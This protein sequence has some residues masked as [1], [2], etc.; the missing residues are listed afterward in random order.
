MKLEIIKNLSRYQEIVEK[1]RRK[2]CI[3]NDYLYAEV[4]DLVLKECLFEC[5]QKDNAFL[6]LRKDKCWRVYYYLNDLSELFSFDEQENFV[7]EIIYRGNSGVSDSEM[8]YLV[9]CGFKPHLTRHLYCGIYNDLLISANTDFVVRKAIS[10]DEVHMACELFNATFDPYSGDYIPDAMIP[11]LFADG[12]IW[13]ATD[14]ENHFAGALH[15][16]IDHGVSWVS[17]VAVSLAFRGRGIGRALLDA[18]VE[19]NH[20]DEKCRFMLWVQANNEP[21]VRMYQNKGFKYV[22]KSSLSMLITKKI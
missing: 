9:K 18:F 11:R 12:D 19:F 16:T 15:Q 5:C 4:A 21:A 10:L 6:F 13:I 20:V 22:N 14:E 8:N 17:H 2:G 1:Y 7:T 3:S